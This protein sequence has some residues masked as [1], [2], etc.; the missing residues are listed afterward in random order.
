MDAFLK[1]HCQRFKFSCVS[2]KVWRDFFLSYFQNKVDA[3]VLD[4]IDWDTW[5]EKP[6]MPPVDPRKAFDTS[7]LDQAAAL[8]QVPTKPNCAT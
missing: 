7:L 2:E 1:A 5:L 8:A 4:S 6:G 3:K